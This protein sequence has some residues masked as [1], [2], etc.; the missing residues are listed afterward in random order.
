MRAPKES[1]RLGFRLSQMVNQDH[2]NFLGLRGFQLMSAT[3]WERLSDAICKDEHDRLIRAWRAHALGRK[4]RPMAGDIGRGQRLN[5]F[6]LPV[7]I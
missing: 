6:G 4:M 2:M 3:A 5:L 7:N 1:G